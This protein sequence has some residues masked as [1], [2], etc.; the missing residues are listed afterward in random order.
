M[1]KGLSSPLSSRAMLLLVS[2]SIALA[3]SVPR[4]ASGRDESPAITA[5]RT[6]KSS[7][8]IIRGTGFTPQSRT[9]VIAIPCADISCAP[10]GSGGLEGDAGP[11]FRSVIVAQDRT[12]SAEL[13]F[14]GAVPVQGADYFLVVAFPGDRA[15]QP[16]DA[17]TRVPASAAVAPGPP[18]TGTGLAPL[19]ASGPP[20]WPLIAAAVT[21]V[22][23][24]ALSLRAHRAD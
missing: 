15:L 16:T 5:T 7:V 20:L 4:V 12:L 9:T 2:A 11:I 14:A 18:A 21:L 6:D 8:W 24:A 22:A 17:W 10:I 19:P 3:I 13:D 23:A 1:K